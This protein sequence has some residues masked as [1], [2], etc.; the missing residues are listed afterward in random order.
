[1][2]KLGVHLS[3]GQEGI[4]VG[5]SNNLKNNDQIV[6]NHRSHAHYLARG[7][8]LN[9]MIAELY[10]KETGTNGGKG[11]SMNL[12]DKSKNFMLA[13]PVVGNSIPVGVGMALEKKISKKK[14]IICIYLGDGATEEGVFYES[15]NFA[16]LHGL[17]CLF[18]IENN[19]YS[20]YTP[21]NQ[22]RKNGIKELHN[23]LN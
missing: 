4:A 22:R 16:N 17:K 23:L 18:V 3:I 20:V 10:G 11:G 5:I 2:K 19:F 13:S 7:C 21:L 6:S 8:S 9:K 12:F 14:D 1:M 15:L